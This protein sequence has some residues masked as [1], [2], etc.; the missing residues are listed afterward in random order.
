M[1]NDARVGGYC[2]VFMQAGNTNAGLHV[3]WA[4]ITYEPIEIVA[5][6]QSSWGKVKSLYKGQ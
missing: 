3:E 1:K 2:Q 4:N 6:E 5:T